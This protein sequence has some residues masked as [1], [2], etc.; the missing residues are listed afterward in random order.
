[1]RIRKSTILMW[2]LWLISIA[3]SAYANIR[4]YQVCGETLVA[5]ATYNIPTCDALTLEVS[6]WYQISTLFLIA[7]VITTIYNFITW[8]IARKKTSKLALTSRDERKEGGSQRRNTGLRGSFS[9]DADTID[10]EV[11]QV[12]PGVFAL[13]TKEGRI[14]HVHYVGRSDIDV[15]AELKENVGKYDR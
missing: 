10:D 12:S 2:T 14:F 8:W 5:A 6:T 1:M 11:D 9:L 13:G 7:S 4:S 3:I 15:K